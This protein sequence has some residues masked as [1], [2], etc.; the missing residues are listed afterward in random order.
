MTDAIGAVIS[1]RAGKLTQVRNIR[2]GT[3]YLSQDACAST[4]ASDRQTSWTRSK[5][6]GPT[7]RRRASR[8]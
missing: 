6:A 5:S 4:S 1:V 3:S 2:S 8:T 7:A